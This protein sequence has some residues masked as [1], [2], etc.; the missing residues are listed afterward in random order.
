MA[1]PSTHTAHHAPEGFIRKYVF[2]LD[3]KV[4]GIQFLFSGLIF[5]VL[6]GLLAMVPARFDGRIGRQGWLGWL[7]LG[8]VI[9]SAFTLSGASAFPGWIALLPVGGAAALIAG[10]GRPVA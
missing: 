4:I 3:H 6:G 7:G 1:S 5:F 10:G 2:S 8:A 9:C